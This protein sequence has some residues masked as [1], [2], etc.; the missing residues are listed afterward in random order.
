MAG[1]QHV[2]EVLLG[3]ELTK[4]QLPESHRPGGMESPFSLP[5]RFR[6]VAVLLALFL[7]CVPPPPAQA[8]DDDLRARLAHAID[9]KKD[10]LVRFLIQ[11][12]QTPSVNGTHTEEA[13]ARVIEAEARRLEL[14][15]EVIAKD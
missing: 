2:K 10:D 13:V 6:L 11:L 4:P 3:R 7:A 5:R 14:A 12:I 8:A 15:V 9:R 1:V